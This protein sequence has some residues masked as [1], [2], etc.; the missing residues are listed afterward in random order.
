MNS[1][2]ASHICKILIANTLHV[3][4]SFYSHLLLAKKLDHMLLAVL[5]LDDK[6]PLSHTTCEL[7]FSLF[8]CTVVARLRGHGAR[9][10]GIFLCFSIFLFF[11]IH[12]L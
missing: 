5:G 3:S 8:D 10:Q 6:W 11:K 7:A 4:I 2:N 9:F 1:L 12:L